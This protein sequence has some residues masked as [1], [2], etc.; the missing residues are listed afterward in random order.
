MRKVSQLEILFFSLCLHT[1]CGTE[2]LG[3]ATKWVRL[4][5]GP[6]WDKSGAFSDQDFSA[7]G[8]GAPNALKSDLKM[9][10]ICPIW[11]P[12]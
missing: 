12:F 2:M 8:A 9:P 4:A 3:L 5:I 6:K 1:A 10:R 11:G 7:F